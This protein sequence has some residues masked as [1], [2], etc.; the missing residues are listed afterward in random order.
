MNCIYCKYYFNVNN[1]VTIKN[2]IHIKLKNLL[3]V[4]NRKIDTHFS[5]F[6]WSFF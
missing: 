6:L 1:I 3:N 4:N 2:N 5:R